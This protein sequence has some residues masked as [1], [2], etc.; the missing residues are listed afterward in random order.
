MQSDDFSP[1]YAAS[2]TGKHDC[3]EFLRV[4]LS[5]PELWR[6]SVISPFT[7]VV[8]V[9][10]RLSIPGELE[11]MVTIGSDSTPWLLGVFNYD[12]KEC[13]VLVWTKE[14]VEGIVD[15][16]KATGVPDSLL[17][18]MLISIKELAAVVVMHATWGLRTR[19]KLYLNLNDN[20]N[21][22]RWVLKRV[23]HNPFANH[24]LLILG[25]LFFGLLT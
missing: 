1:L 20:Y 6:T 17:D 11:N 22:C 13:G 25:R 5:D 19:G 7:H 12:T 16:L 3:V 21:A 23:A 2:E 4:Q 9:A 24:L 10:E 18:D 8:S 14:V 15:A